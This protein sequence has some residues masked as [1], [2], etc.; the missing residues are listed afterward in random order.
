MLLD[1]LHV[2]FHG[3]K[4]CLAPLD[5]FVFKRLRRFINFYLLTVTYLAYMTVFDLEQSLNSAEIRG[6]PFYDFLL[7]GKHSPSS[8]A[9]F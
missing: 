5:S 6:N 2:T 3:G 1:R 8:C 9:M 7:V 4:C